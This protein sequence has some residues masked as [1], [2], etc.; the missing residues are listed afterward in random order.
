MSFV[1][2]LTLAQLCFLFMNLAQAQTGRLG[3]TFSIIDTFSQICL[4]A[5]L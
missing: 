5:C 2:R 1:T 4:R 3:K